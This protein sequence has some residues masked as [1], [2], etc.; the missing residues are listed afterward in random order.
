MNIPIAML[1]HV[2]DSPHPSL[3]DWTISHHKFL[4]LLDC[5]EEKNL[6]TTTFEEIVTAKSNDKKLENKVILTFDDC[7]ASLFDFAIPELIRR[8]MK[9][10]F[11]M[12]T[13]FIGDLNV[14]DIEDH[15]TTA[16]KLMDASQILE[17]SRLGMEI[18]S[19]GE[20]HIKLNRV[21]Q[22]KAFEDINHSKITLEKIL[23]KPVYSFAYPY[24]K[25]PR[26]H[27][28]MLHQAGYQV[29]ISIYTSFQSQLTLRRFGISQ[30]DDTKTILLKLSPRYRMM[31][32]FYDPVF[33]FKNFLF[34]LNLV[35]V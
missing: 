32:A 18:G 2:A 24:G 19:H 22:H 34:T 26:Y 25:I 15:G 10:V 31:R 30:S 13:A 17:L 14:W 12:P 6:Q 11:Y 9:A 4:K 35:P 3:K 1:H 28:K 7:P 8:D 23:N 21:P 16:V 27:K 33:L 20:R 5:I 29:G